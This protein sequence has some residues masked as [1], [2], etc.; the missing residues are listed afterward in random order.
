MPILFEACLRRTVLSVSGWFLLVCI[1]GGKKLSDMQNEGRG[2][3]CIRN[4][5]TR[6]ANSVALVCF[7]LKGRFGDFGGK[8]NQLCTALNK[9][10]RT[11][12]TETLIFLGEKQTK[13]EDEK[14]GPA[15]SSHLVGTV[16]Q[17][18]A[19]ANG[20]LNNSKIK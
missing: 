10:K 5:L 7:R 8:E 14:R 2:S 11:I 15:D 4:T 9:K 18:R 6:A 16:V 13:V 1:L 19:E 12:E 17:Q 3:K 20:I